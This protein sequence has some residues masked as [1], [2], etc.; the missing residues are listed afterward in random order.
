MS[1]KIDEINKTDIWIALISIKVFQETLNYLI[2]IQKL[3]YKEQKR[4][5]MKAWGLVERTNAWEHSSEAFAMLDKKMTVEA[6]SY[7][8][9][10]TALAIEICDQVRLLSKTLNISFPNIS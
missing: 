5:L 10:Y 2:D 6:I 4:K 9:W 8:A 1:E 7:W 3:D